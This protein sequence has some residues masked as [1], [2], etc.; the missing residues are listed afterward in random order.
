MKSGWTRATKIVAAVALAAT[1]ALT[2]GCGPAPGYEPEPRVPVAYSRGSADATPEPLTSDELAAR[3][4]QVE[5]A[6]VAA[7]GGGEGDVAL[8]E[9]ADEYADTD[10]SALTEFKPVLDGH[11]TW[12]DD[13]AYGTVWVPSA[14]EVGTDFVPYSTAGRWTYDDSTSWVWVSDYS[15]GWAPFHYGRWV[16]VSRH[17]WAWIPGRTY[18]G[19][20]VTWRVGSPGY[21]YLGWSPAAPSW[22]WRNGYALGWHHPW[23]PYYSYCHYDHV[24][25][26]NV[27]TRVIRGPAAAPHEERTRTYVAAAPAVSGGG[28]TAAAPSVGPGR[29]SAA[30]T[31]GNDRVAA[32]PAVGARAGALPRVGPRPQ[33]IGIRNDVVVAPPSDNSGLARAQ[34]LASP[35][36]AVTQG[37]APPISVARRA[38]SPS[39][40]GGN[41]GSAFNPPGS[42]PRSG[43]FAATM[44][45]GDGFRGPVSESRTPAS[46]SRMEAA[47]RAPQVQGIAPVPARQQP[48]DDP[49]PEPGIRSGQSWSAQNAPAVTTPGYRTPSSPNIAVPPPSFRSQPQAPSQPSVQAQPP[50]FRPSPGPLPEFRSSS[51]AFRSQSPAQPQVRAMPQQ[52]QFRSAPQPQFRAS[53]QPQ[54]RSSPSVSSP[55]PSFRSAPSAPTF[56]SSPSVSSPSFRS[57]PSPRI[58]APSRSSASPTFRSRR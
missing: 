36:T 44:P 40:D 30:P 49:R 12:V 35:R 13:P 11:G 42:P 18:S 50:Q 31:V 1:G 47:A 46:P 53:P 8:G 14:A 21:S 10:P 56:R 45:R 23:T 32:A 33:E 5:A 29:T 22:Y 27:G 43:A 16:N 15:W 19:A 41:A 20:W 4:E 58:S 38:A 9:D 7:S 28:R 57:A 6:R 54:F 55:P 3:A 37:A 39:F 24:Y 25:S 48:F 51:P 34:I 17:G 2:I 52:P 26:P